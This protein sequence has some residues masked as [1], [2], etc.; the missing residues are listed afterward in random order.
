MTSSTF[1]VSSATFRFDARVIETY[2]SREKVRVCVY[3]L[4]WQFKFI[5]ISS[6]CFVL[7][8]LLYEF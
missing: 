7:Q 1:S 6:P 8:V 2:R 3:Y 5:C 4:I